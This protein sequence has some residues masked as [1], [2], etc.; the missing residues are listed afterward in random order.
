[1][2]PLSCPDCNIPAV[3][4]K[5]SINRG[6]DQSAGVELTLPRDGSPRGFRVV[7]SMNKKHT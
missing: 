5:V 1:M 4:D 6:N 7:I 2:V 3:L